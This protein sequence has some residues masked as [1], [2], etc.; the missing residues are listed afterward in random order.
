MS[1]LGLMKSLANKAHNG[2]KY[3]EEFPYVLHLQAV[4][5]VLLRFGVVDEELR[6]IAWGH[7]LLE[8]TTT[9][10]EDLELFFGTI[11]A[12]AIADLS[13]PKGGNRKWRHA[14]TYPRIRRNWRST[15]IKLADRIANVESGG[16]KGNM[17]RR[18]YP[19]FKGALFTLDSVPPPHIRQ[20]LE[21]MWG[22][23]D[24]LMIA[25]ELE[26]T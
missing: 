6:S 1:R 12:D 25:I 10:Y 8:D 14:Q 7:D 15:L 13:E 16:K 9:A 22:H 23:L 17:Y 3:G 2:Q 26:N 20:V 19:D 11:I 18:E 21:G 5:G 4:E 24:N